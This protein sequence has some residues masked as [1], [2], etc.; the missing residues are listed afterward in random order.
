MQRVI[1]SSAR[2]GADGTLGGGAAGAAVR[3]VRPGALR[4]H[5]GGE[6]AAGLPGTAAAHG[7]QAEGKSE[8]ATVEEDGAEHMSG[9]FI[10]LQQDV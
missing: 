1:E 8:G 2:F 7:A 10:S 4:G 9:Q 6:R 3:A 5:G